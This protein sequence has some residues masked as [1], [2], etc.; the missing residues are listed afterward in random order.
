VC[1][2]E[3]VSAVQRAAVCRLGLAATP[4]PSSTVSAASARFAWARL[5]V[6][7]YLFVALF[8]SGHS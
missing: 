7:S 5:L 3:Q 4:D 6:R 1:S 2:A 8:G